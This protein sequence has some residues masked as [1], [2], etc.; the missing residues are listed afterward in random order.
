MQVDPERMT[1]EVR[2]QDPFEVTR[3]EVEAE[4]RKLDPRQVDRDAVQVLEGEVGVGGTSFDAGL[5]DSEDRL[6]EMFLSCRKVAADREGACK[7]RRAG[8]RSVSVSPVGTT[9]SEVGEQ[10]MMKTHG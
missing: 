1:Q 3:A 10:P 8:S 2:I 4:V 6:V 9:A 5:F 7:Q